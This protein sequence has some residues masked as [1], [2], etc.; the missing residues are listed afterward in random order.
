MLL[1]SGLFSKAEGDR[2]NNWK[3]HQWDVPSRHQGPFAS[4]DKEVAPDHLFQTDLTDLLQTMGRPVKKAAT[5]F[6]I[7]CGPKPPHA[8]I[9]CNVSAKP[10]LYNITAD[11]CEYHNLADQMPQ[12]VLKMMERLAQY[13]KTAVPPGNKPQD[14][15]GF[16]INNGGLWVP[17]ITLTEEDLPE[18]YVRPH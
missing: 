10:C 6:V 17:W 11:P 7:N 3:S 12:A 5:P 18:G 16:P 13:N 15:K 8:A 14:P 4:T 1:L 2:F 9:N